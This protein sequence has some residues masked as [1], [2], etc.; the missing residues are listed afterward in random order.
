MSDILNHYHCAREAFNRLP[1]ES[2]MTKAIINNFD[3]FRL[4]SQGP[5]FLYYDLIDPH[6][7]S[8]HLTAQTIHSS[9]IDDFFYYGLEFSK[10]FPEYREAAL[11]YLAG[12]SSHH[13]LD[14]NTHPFIFHRTGKYNPNDKE[15]RIYSYLHK[16]YEVLLDT[17]MTQYE[18][19]TQAVFQSPEKV[20]LV[21]PLTLKFIEAFYDYVLPRAY[22]MKLP[23]NTISRSLKHAVRILIH[24]KDPAGRRKRLVKPLERLLGEE[25]L[26]SRMFYPFYT[27]EFFILNI[28]NAPWKNPVTGEVHTESYPE[29]YHRAV[30]QSY[31]N[32]NAL[33]ELSEKENLNPEEVSE[34]FKNRSYLT[35]LDARD[36][37]EIKYFD[38]AFMKRLKDEF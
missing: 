32:F 27:N 16:L 31:N 8:A 35:G 25:Y 9:N 11:A 38:E 34:L 33:Y 36:E 6:A 7:R 19:S 2:P 3:A 5:D 26:L 37:R 21:S 14:T 29:L 1:E 23:K 13:A 4:G 17:A 18:Y 15:T 10:K 24:C 20:F 12:F 30:D 22:S 28:N